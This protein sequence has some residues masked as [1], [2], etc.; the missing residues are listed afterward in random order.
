MARSLHMLTFGE[1]RSRHDESPFVPSV[2]GPEGDEDDDFDPDEDG[3][4]HD[5]DN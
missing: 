2:P 1:L 5:N 3:D 4:E